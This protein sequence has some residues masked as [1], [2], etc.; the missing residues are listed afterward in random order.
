MWE[1]VRE[2]LEPGRVI[3][4]VLRQGSRPLPVAAVAELWQRDAAFRVFF[5]RLLAD[6]PF[7]AYFWEMPPLTCAN[8]VRPFEC[9][10]ANSPALAGVA[11][12]ATVFAGLFRTACRDEPVIAFP[13]LGGDALLVTPCPR[14][15]SAA[16][17]HL[18][19]FVRHAPEDQ[20]HAL[21]RLLGSVIA[22]R[23][24]ER[25]LWVSTSGLGVY[26]LHVRL[27]SRPKYYT[28]R[29]YTHW[30]CP[31]TAGS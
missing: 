4:I 14:T 22:G 28:Y 3:R 9:I 10:V 5:N 18:A 30:S 27:D 13:N 20:R 29:P 8:R 11:P 6:A 7:A 15:P 2:V 19:A 26:W 25:P 31:G 1:A 16:Y 23:L 12:D 24:G 21:W 17:P